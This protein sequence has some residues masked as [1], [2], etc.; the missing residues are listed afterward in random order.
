MEFRMLDLNREENKVLDDMEALIKNAWR[1]VVENIGAYTEAYER[2]TSIWGRET[3]TRAVQNGSEV[4]LAYEGERLVGSVTVKF[5]KHREEDAICLT[6]LVVDPQY[7]KRGYGKEIIGECERIYREKGCKWVT[8]YTSGLLDRLVNY[9]ESL[10]FTR[11][12]RE[13]VFQYGKEYFRV[14]LKRNCSQGC[15]KVIMSKETITPGKERWSLLFLY[16]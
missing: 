14:S 2:D 8:L 10:G 4:L 3:L 1:R 9:Y 13:Q 12:K 11:W 5:E 15:R 6:R 7:R 16:L